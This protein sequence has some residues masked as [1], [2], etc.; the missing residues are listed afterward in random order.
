[1]N[2]RPIEFIVWDFQNNR[3]ANQSEV[4]PSMGLRFG[5]NDYFINIAG[6]KA[7]R[8]KFCQFIGITDKLGEKLFDGD[9]VKVKGTKR[10]GEYLTV[11]EWYL[12]GYRLRSNR[13][14]V[15]DGC[16]LRSMFEKV[17]NIYSHP[18]YSHL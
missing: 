5:T 6:E 7:L 15:V 1:M 17:G 12:T 14:R 11:I 13:T 8:F 9:V 16:L 3:W 4:L 10:V 2:Q 18:E